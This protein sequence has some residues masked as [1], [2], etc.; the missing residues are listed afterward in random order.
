MKDLLRK[1]RKRKFTALNDELSITMHAL[2][3]FSG[4]VSIIKTFRKIKYFE[5]YHGHSYIVKLEKEN[6][7][8]LK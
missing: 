8:S 3:S 2:D 6:V 5:T 1:T 4:N 7:M